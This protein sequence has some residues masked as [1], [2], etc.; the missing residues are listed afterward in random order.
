ME[1]VDYLKVH[2]GH[3]EQSDFWSLFMVQVVSKVNFN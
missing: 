2:F 3:F 1:V